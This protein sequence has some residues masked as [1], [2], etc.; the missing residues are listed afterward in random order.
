MYFRKIASFPWQFGLISLDELI[1]SELFAKGRAENT[2]AKL[3][4]AVQIWKRSFT[5]GR[6]AQIQTKMET[7]LFCRSEFRSNLWLRAYFPF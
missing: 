4:F 7:A 5:L 6:Q 1:S 2:T 3:V